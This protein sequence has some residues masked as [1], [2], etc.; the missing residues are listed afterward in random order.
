MIDFVKSFSAQ[1]TSIPWSGLGMAGV[2]PQSCTFVIG[3][4]FNISRAH[5]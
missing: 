2:T 5:G 3:G 4:F 1:L